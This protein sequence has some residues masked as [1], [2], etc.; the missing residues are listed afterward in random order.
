MQDKIKMQRC[1]DPIAFC[2]RYSFYEFASIVRYWRFS[3]FALKMEMNGTTVESYIQTR[4]PRYST[5]EE[6]IPYYCEMEVTKLR[7]KRRDFSFAIKDVCE[8]NARI[9]KNA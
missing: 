8:T 7:E 5:F 2:H 4:T 3:R 1:D 9:F 6:N